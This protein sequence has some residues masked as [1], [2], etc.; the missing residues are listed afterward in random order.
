MSVRLLRACVGYL[1]SLLL[2]FVLVVAG[3]VVVRGEPLL[4]LLL[5]VLALLVGAGLAVFLR[6]LRAAATGSR[7]AAAWLLGIAALL[8]ASAAL[9]VLWSSGHVLFGDRDDRGRHL[10]LMAFNVFPL[11]IDLVL[12]SAARAALH[13]GRQPWAPLLHD[14]G[15]GRGWRSDLARAA[16]VNRWPGDRRP[17]PRR[18]VVLAWAAF[19][20]EGLA[21]SVY[22]IPNDQLVEVAEQ[23]QPV[24]TTVGLVGLLVTVLGGA[25]LLWLLLRAGTALRTRAQRLAQPS[26]QEL[27]ALDPRPPVLFLRSFHDDQVTL[28]S[29]RPP[30]ALRLVDPGVRS[31]HLEH[32][33]VQ[34]YEVLGPLVAVGR[35]GEPR[36]PVGAGRQYLADERWQDVVASSMR[37]AAGIV[38][39][40]AEGDGLAWELAELARAGH[41]HKTT[42]VV[43]PDRATDPP[44]VLDRLAQVDP[45]LDALRSDLQPPARAPGRPSALLAATYDGPDQCVL[46][47]SSRVTELEYDLALRFTARRRAAVV[48]QATATARQEQ[49][50]RPVG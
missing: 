4:L 20:V 47:W 40:L 33:L 10:L 49:P 3:S 16:G 37:Q 32:L 14:H 22:L 42:F 2:V 36:V 26:L 35:P 50:S 11:Y 7:Q 1:L 8:A 9:Q 21:F 38:V 45:R 27:R 41:L 29:A 48:A 23:T 12:V 17:V 18:A 34:D 24:S 39:V 43:P 46:L 31:R 6:V 44:Q 19:V 13:A 30:L 28:D 5:P 25:V 15:Y